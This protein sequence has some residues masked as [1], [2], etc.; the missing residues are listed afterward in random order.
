MG[1]CE[2]ARPRLAPPCGT[3]GHGGRAYRHWPHMQHVRHIWTRRQCQGHFSRY[4]K[5]PDA[6]IYAALLSRQPESFRPGCYLRFLSSLQPRPQGPCRKSGCEEAGPPSHDIP[7]V[8]SLAPSG[9]PCL[10]PT[11]ARGQ[12]AMPAALYVCS[13]VSS[14]QSI[15]AFC[16]ARATAALCLPR[17]SM[18]PLPH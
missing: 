12:G 8:I 2:T 17:R 10:P 3:V 14:P 5:A 9:R 18:S 1:P 4:R 16:L 15:R 11:T 6:I 7:A 13:L